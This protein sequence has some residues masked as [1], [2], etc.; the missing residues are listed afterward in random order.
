MIKSVLHLGDGIGQRAWLRS[1]VKTFQQGLVNAG[2]PIGVDGRFGRG[3]IEAGKAFQAANGLEQTGIFDKAA[4]KAMADHLSQTSSDV[5]ALLENFDGDLDW[6]HQQEGHM[7]R[8]YWPGGISGVTLDPGVD[9]GHASSDFIETLYRP[10]LT[11][12]QMDALR[13]V[14]GF[15]G[16]DA[17]DALK[18]SPVTQSIRITA[19]QGIK[20][21]PHTAKPYWSGSTRRFSALTRKDTPASVQ[22][23]LLSLAYN[24][25][26]LNRHLNTLGTPLNAKKWDKV[27]TIIGSMQQGHKQKG[28]RVRRR[29][30][31]M[32]IEAELDFLAS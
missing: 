21:M 24:R 30:E 6:V 27:A 15:K 20:L 3:T 23:V 4:W 31:R 9:L 22:T 7:G 8:P 28:I 11:K 32:V 29:Q 1:V 10:L 18:L 13:L 14:F 12:K 17:R 5:K 26:I 2:H 19:D 25:G 16:E